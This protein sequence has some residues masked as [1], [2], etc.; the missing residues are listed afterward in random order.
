M[1]SLPPMMKHR[2]LLAALSGLMLGFSF[3]PLHLGAMAFVGFVPL[4][5]ALDGVVGKLRVLR[6]LYV[7]FF[8]FCGASNW[9][10]ISWQKN[11]DPYLM[12]SGVALWIGHPFFFMLPVIAYR[13]A[14]RWLGR[15][16]SL[17][18][19]PAFWTG[20]EWLHSLTDASYPWLTIGYSQIYHHIPVQIADI[21]GVWLVSLLVTSVNALLASAIFAYF[22][23]NEGHSTTIRMAFSAIFRRKEIYIAATLILCASIYGT[24]RLVSVK[25]QMATAT[26]LSAGVIQPDIDPWTKWAGGVMGQVDLHKHLQDSLLRLRK[27][28]VCV[29]C[30]TSI[31]Y[32]GMTRSTPQGLSF[33]QS[34]IDSTDA[35]LLTGFSEIALYPAAVA[36]PT[37]RMLP[38]DSS[39]FFGAYNAAALLPV[40]GSSSKTSVHRKMRLTPFAER[41]PFV[42]LFPFAKKWLEWGV[43]ISDWQKGEEQRT[44]N[45]TTHGKEVRLGCIICIE[46]VYPD[47]VRRYSAQDANVFSVI[48]NDAWYNYTFGPEQH[49]QIAAMRAIENR[50]SIIRCGNSGVSGFISPT[51]ASISRAE[52]YISLAAAEEVPLMNE[53]TLYARFGDWL[54]MLLTLLAGA[55]LAAGYMRRRTKTVSAQK[56]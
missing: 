42:E 16:W 7:A 3:P 47:F 35:A 20:F 21:G 49:Y 4:L 32:L 55:G 39:Y 5:L 17:A 53:Q 19:F 56:S 51:G 11:T 1:D 10:I 2:Y 52:P 8:C 38:F 33:L 30:E 28:D 18:L 24:F 6:V 37:A 46:S 41:I 50:R 34:W 48:T 29:W 44:L 23:A 22:R 13:Y 54:P 15:T 27:T 25:K 9:W 40:S 36:P 14:A 26:M 43:G 31:P 45:F 12:A